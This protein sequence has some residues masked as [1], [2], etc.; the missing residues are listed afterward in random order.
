MGGGG[1]DLI[2]VILL[3]NVR[4]GKS[5]DSSKNAKVKKKLEKGPIIDL[6]N[7]KHQYFIFCF[8]YIP[9]EKNSIRHYSVEIH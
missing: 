9:M 4:L 6:R 5:K 1:I 7:F 3:L 8:K 2:S